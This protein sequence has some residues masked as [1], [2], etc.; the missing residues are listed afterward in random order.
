MRDIKRIDRIMGALKAK[1][2]KYPDMRFFQ[3]MV[4]MG[5][6]QDTYEVWR[7]EDDKVEKH[8]KKVKQL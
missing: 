7:L 8:I 4:N 5:L 6:V 2:K 3:F 1:W